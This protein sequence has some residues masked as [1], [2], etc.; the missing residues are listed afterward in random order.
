MGKRYIAYEIQNKQPLLIT[1]L[2]TSKPGEITTLQYL[3]GSTLRGMVISNLKE[4]MNDEESKQKILTKAVFYNG[5]PMAGE[6]E[7]I[8]SPKGFCE[9]KKQDGALINIV[10][11]NSAKIEGYKRAALGRF[12]TLKGTTVHYTSAEV[13]DALS[14]NV[15]DENIFRKNV[16]SAGQCF[17]AYIAVGEEEEELY[18]WLKDAVNEQIGYIGSYRTSGF[19]K[20]ETKY[21][22][23]IIPYQ[24]IAKAEG[25]QNE[26][27]LYLASNM[28]M[29][30][31]QGEICGIDLNILAGLLEV[32]E[33]SLEASSTSICK[34]S[35]INRQ[36][37][38]RTP[39]IVMY[40]AGSVF[41]L[42]SVEGTITEE[43]MKRVSQNGIGVKREE[44]CGQILFLRDY[45]KI[46]KKEELSYKTEEVAVETTLS[47]EEKEQLKFVAK[48][49]AKK[50]IQK[51]I[52]QYVAEQG[53]DRRIPKSQRGIMLNHAKYARVEGMNSVGRIEK[54]L[55]HEKE[56]LE[57]NKRQ[58]DNQGKR[59]ALEYLEKM[60]RQ[61]IFEKLGLDKDTKICGCP[62]TELFTKE[63]LQAYQMEMLEKVIRFE[64]RRGKESRVGY[65]YGNL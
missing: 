62:V 51:A 47:K 4:K 61:D 34:V 36:W 37:G 18:Q 52:E 56:K 19:G 63:E 57:R 17:R 13:E 26:V 42:K 41:R 48:E 60:I 28:S 31:E 6:E 16:L 39:E 50:R 5:Y 30:N 43:A 58:R 65:E 33:L 12:C 23:D 10:S 21:I 27:Y 29:R 2:D 38:C 40:E 55:E 9:N 46:E 53:I 3:P 25:D 1:N 64:N 24:N 32:G 22:K 14:I 35:G 8:P 45:D 20:C 54:Y 11:D 7:L 59:V 49:I 15:K 44:G